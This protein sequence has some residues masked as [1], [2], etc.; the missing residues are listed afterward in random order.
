MLRTLLACAALA[1][2]ALPCRA[3]EQSSTAET[4]IRLNVQPAPAP[5]PALR[6]LLLPALGEM[7]PGNPIQNYLKCFMEQQ[8][9]FFDKEAF[10]RREKL[11]AMPLG[12]LPARELEDYGQ[13]ALAQADW[14]ARLDNPDWQILLKLKRDGVSTLL[15]DV[16][17]LRS[18]T[19]ALKVRFRGEVALGHFDDALRSAKTMFALARHLGEHPTFIGTLVGIATASMAMDPLEEMLQQPGCPNLYW[20][21]TNLPDPLI[22]LNKGREGER[23]LIMAEFR[24]LDDSAPMTTDQLERV[25][26]HLVSILEAG[27]PKLP[28]MGVRARLDARSHDDEKLAAARGRLV[29]F[30]IPEERLRRF[31]SEQVILLDEKRECEERMD[32]SLKVL[33]LPAWQAEALAPQLNV[34]KPRALFDLFVPPPLNMRRAQGRVEQKVALLRHVEALRL[35]A[36]EHKGALPAKL[37]ELTVPLPVDPFSG[38]PIRYEAEGN[39]AHLRGTPPTGY[40]KSAPYNLHYEVT[41][42]K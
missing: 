26:S 34:K 28:G 3:S 13:A 40:E 15:P 41:I 33:N 5:K 37:S 1:I 39:T 8:K 9:F 14:A 38:K 24:G 20:A 35:Y 7:N 16:Q 23:L 21:L 30:G 42:Q 27:Q 17:Q 29:A 22:S 10:E 4:L 11:L 32:D 6:Y 2:F 19:K 36:A 12:E 25:I 18:L 31:P